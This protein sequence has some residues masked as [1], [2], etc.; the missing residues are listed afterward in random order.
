MYNCNE[1]FV[2]SEIARLFKDEAAYK[3]IMEAEDPVVQKRTPIQNFD[4]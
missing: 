1:Q 3:L 2:K 4:R